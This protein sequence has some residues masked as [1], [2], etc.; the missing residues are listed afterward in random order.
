MC[1]IKTTTGSDWDID[2]FNPTFTKT[3]AELFN[4][5]K[6][7]YKVNDKIYNWVDSD[8]KLTITIPIPGLTKEDIEVNINNKVLIVKGNK[9]AA[10]TNKFQRKIELPT[11]VDVKTCVAK[12][13]NG[14][15][16]IE[17]LK[18]EDYKEIKIKID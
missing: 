7:N 13:E 17:F 15:V 11:I 10:F 8:D 4:D 2:V 1:Y 14:L 18:N 9:D 5:W 16:I 12:V 6:P 3:F